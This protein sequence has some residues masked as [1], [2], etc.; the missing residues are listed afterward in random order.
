MKKVFFL[1]VAAVFILTIKPASAEKIPANARKLIRYYKE[2]ISGFQNNH[3]VFTDGTRMKW[4]DGI[5]NKSYQ[6]LLD[7]PDLEDMFH[8]KYNKRKAKIPLPVNYD[9]GR[10]RVEPFFLKL[11]GESADKVREN[12]REMVWCPKLVGQKIRVSTLYGADKQFEKISKELDQYPEFAPYLTKIAGTFNWRKIAG[13]DRLSMHSFGMT[14]DINTRFTHY[15]QWDCK[16]KNEDVV[17]GYQNN[18]PLKIVRIFEKHGFVW[19]GKWYH[20]DTM[21]FEYRPELM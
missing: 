5:E 12:L 8:D 20:Y 17:L 9:P 13:T 15:W 10:I 3:I 2:R 4:D 14:M 11:Y 21:H 6:Q 19:G 16:C 1:I 7:V 18:I